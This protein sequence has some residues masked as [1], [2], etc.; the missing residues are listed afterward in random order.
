MKIDKSQVKN[1]IS[2]IAGAAIIG[3]AIAIPLFLGW[4]G[5]NPVRN[6]KTTVQLLQALRSAASMIH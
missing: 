2:L 6:I 1:D 4:V 5:K 3:S